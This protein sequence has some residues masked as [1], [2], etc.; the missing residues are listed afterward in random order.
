M[1]SPT[2]SIPPLSHKDLLRFWSRVRICGPNDCWPW[3]AG[4]RRDGYG[5]FGLWDG[6]VRTNLYAHRVAWTLAHGPIPPGLCV[7]HRCDAPLCQ[8]PRHLFLGTPADNMRDRDRKGRSATGERHGRA[9]LTD[10]K[11]RAIRAAYALGGV[12]QST[13]AKRHHVGRWAICQ[14]LTRK[15]WAHVIPGEDGQ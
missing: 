4:R 11:V 13:L 5:K 12:T 7:C 15:T 8:N 14:V 3:T 1:R 6:I 2:R 9:K 10:A